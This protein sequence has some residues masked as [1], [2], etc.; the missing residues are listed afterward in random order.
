MKITSLKAQEI[1]DSRGNP[2][3]ECVTTLSDGSTGWAA[4]P[5]GA[6]TGKYEAVELRDSDPKRFG[7]Q[8]VLL[9][10]ANVNNVLSKV[11]MGLDASD[12]AQLDR[13]MIDADGTENKA[14][15]GANAILS[16][17]M[18]AARAAAAS[19][20]KP[21]YEYLSK[22]NPDYKD[23]YIMPLTMLNVL[24]GGKHGNWASDIQE[25][26]L[27]PT[28]A[29][30]TCDSIRMGVEVYHALKKILKGKGYSVAVG[31]EGGYAP[32]FQSNE[33]PFQIMMDAIIEAGYTPG[34][35]F[36]LGID[37]AA[38]EFYKEGK[39][40]LKKEGLVL[41]TDELVEFY[42]NLWK[43]YP[44]VS[45]E[46]IFDQ[47]DWY[48]FKQLYIKSEGNMQVMGDDLFVTNIKRLKRGIDEKTCNSILI[49]L[50]QIGTV[51]E[52]VSAILMA[53]TA[54]MTAIVSHRSAETEDAFMA[55]FVVAMGTGQIKTGAPARSE[56]TAK[57][58]QLM[59]IERELGDKATYA[60]FPFKRRS[61]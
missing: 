23:T 58:N 52:T 25:Y 18:S 8:G 49:K 19:E 28:G 54:G 47:D 55:D 14:K 20:K 10:V 40:H 6:S 12:Q 24:N 22:F 36:N 53:R 34:K 50:N 2:T 45:M 46:D 30:N 37:G 38:S 57:Y 44:I 9:A 60:Q 1:L 11:V 48:G 4:V 41:S 35:D 42:L 56:R 16:V 32:Q 27:F 3:I 61:L 13:K 21:L 15:L 5:S 29:T 43:K 26:I 33:E 59:R 17:S 31:D 51:S 7:G 39:Y